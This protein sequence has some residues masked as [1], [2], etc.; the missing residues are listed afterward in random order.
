MCHN[1]FQEWLS[2]INQ[3]NPAQK[4]RAKNVLQGETEVVASLEKTKA[5]L[6]ETRM[7]P[8]CG[9]FGRVPKGKAQELRRY[10]YKVC[11]KSFNAATNIRP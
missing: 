11:K 2:A 1:Q 9:T 7:C 8:H 4:Q 5:K 6:A 3:F 10:L